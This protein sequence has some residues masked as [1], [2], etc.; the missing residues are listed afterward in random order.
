MGISRRSSV[1][2]ENFTIDRIAFV[3]GNDPTGLD[4]SEIF[5]SVSITEGI[6]QGLLKGSMD[7]VDSMNLINTINPRGDEKI[8]ISFRS[9][10]LNG[11]E[12]KTYSKMFKILRYEDITSPNT[13][14][15]KYVRMYF[16]SEEEMNNEY[17]KVSKSYLNTSIH[18]IIKDML[19]LIGFKDDYIFIEKT[20][21]NRDIVIPNLTPLSVIN[22]LAQNSQSSEPN[23]KG[24][25]NFYF[26]EDINGVNFKSGTTLMIEEPKVDLT[27]EATHDI[28]MY[29]KIIKLQRVKGYNLAEQYRSG[30][31]GVDVHTMSITNKSYRSSYQDYYGVKQIYPKL[32]PEPWFGGEITPERNTCVILSNEDQMYKYINIGSNGNSVGIRTTNRASLNAKRMLIQ[33]PGNTDLSCGNIVN[34]IAGDTNG[35]LTSKDA[36]HW[37]VNSLTHTLTRETYFISAELISDSD[38]RGKE[39]KNDQ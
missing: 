8:Q 24:D 35:E 16:Q 19:N 1:A 36:G 39:R 33:I 12:A 21:Y 17:R 38:I 14:I 25:S 7:F 3:Q 10:H 32:N 9:V 18:S 28:S 30:G 23:A 26:Y 4:I 31:L 37:L 20:L 34:I 29:N 2:Y 6:T 5:K 13:Q 11:E 22:H 27:F 15:K